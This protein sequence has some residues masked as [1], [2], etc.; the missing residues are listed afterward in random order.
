MTLKHLLYYAFHMNDLISFSHELKERRAHYVSIQ[1]MR[2]LGPREGSLLPNGHID[3]ERWRPSD[4]NVT[5]RVGPGLGSELWI[6]ALI[7]SL[8]L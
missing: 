7:I 6:P 4:H 5:V 2:K 1:Q 3:G 8:I